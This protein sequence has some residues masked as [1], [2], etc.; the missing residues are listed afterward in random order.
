MVRLAEQLVQDAVASGQFAFPPIVDVRI[1]Q[2]Q[3]ELLVDR[4]KAGSM[5][6]T[7]GQVGADVSSLLSGNFVNR[8]SLDGR[9]Y[10][11]I[12]Q[13]QRVSRLLPRQLDDLYVT[14][15]RNC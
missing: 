7:M 13:V 4:G 12:P 15:P 9:S 3:T 8:F 14:V 5:G 6:L 10:K 11:V 2:T 1:D